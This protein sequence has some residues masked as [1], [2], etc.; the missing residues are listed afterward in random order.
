M[1][2]FEKSFGIAF[3]SRDCDRQ[4]GAHRYK[5]TIAGDDSTEETVNLRGK[6]PVANALRNKRKRES[7]GRERERG[8]EERE[9]KR[10]KTRQKAKEGCNECTQEVADV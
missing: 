8:G 10:K 4:R 2:R 7:G 9:E 1:S 5:D 6:S 3:R